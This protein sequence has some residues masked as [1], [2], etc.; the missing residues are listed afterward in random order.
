MT[1]INFHLQICEIWKQIGVIVFWCT[2]SNI[3]MGKNNTWRMY[4]VLRAHL[5]KWSKSLETF[6]QTESRATGQRNRGHLTSSKISLCIICFPKLNEWLKREVTRLFWLGFLGITVK[7]ETHYSSFGNINT[8]SS[9]QFQQLL[10][11]RQVN[12]IEGHEYIRG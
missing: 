1:N 7:K 8:I 2:K 6:Q 12:Y 5:K 9:N 11:G 4:I 3:W 10:F